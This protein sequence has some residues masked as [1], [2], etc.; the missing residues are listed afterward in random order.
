M[1]CQVLCGRKTCV[2][3]W[4][5]AEYLDFQQR[6]CD[7]PIDCG[8][9]QLNPDEPICTR[10]IKTKFS[11]YKYEKRVIISAIHS[12]VHYKW[13]SKSKFHNLAERALVKVPLTRFILWHR[14][15]S[16]IWETV[17]RRFVRQQTKYIAPQHIVRR[18]HSLRHKLVSVI[19]TDRGVIFRGSRAALALYTLS[20]L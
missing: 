18:I 6:G 19:I 17:Q 3:H 11:R 10:L 2:Y 16:R 5:A 4:K 8:Q 9:F 1:W 14:G 15:M 12:L 7:L 20:N 13:T